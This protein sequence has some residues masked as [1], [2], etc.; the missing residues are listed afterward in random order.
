MGQQVAKAMGEV[1]AMDMN[2]TGAVRELR[3]PLTE[4]SGVE[5]YLDLARCIPRMP[6]DGEYDNAWMQLGVAYSL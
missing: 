4:N 2:V 3:K 1:D 5:D 6:A